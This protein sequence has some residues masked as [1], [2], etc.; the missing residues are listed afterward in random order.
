MGATIQYKGR[1]V[2]QSDNFGK[3]FHLARHS[4]GGCV[5]KPMGRAILLLLCVGQYQ[6]LRFNFGVITWK[7]EQY[8]RIVSHSSSLYLAI[9]KEITGVCAWLSWPCNMRPTC[10]PARG[11]I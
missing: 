10:L 2:Q 7:M 11:L 5:E 3:Q 6:K 8:A 4:I 1:A 9:C